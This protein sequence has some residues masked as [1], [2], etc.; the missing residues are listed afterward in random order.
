[1]PLGIILDITPPYTSIPKVKGVTSIKRISFV[2]S[3]V[4]PP[5][6]PP[7]TAAP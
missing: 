4:S 1:V 2:Y 5:K 3:L 6:M 7:Y